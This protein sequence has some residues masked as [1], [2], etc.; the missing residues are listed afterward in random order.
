MTLAIILDLI[1][2]G[3]LVATISYA[4]ILNRRLITIQKS[5]TELQKFIDHFT[6]SLAKAEAS[7]QELKQTGQK[8]M[9]SVLEPLPQAKVL[10]D[11]LVF[12]LEKGESLAER[13][14]NFIRTARK[15]G[16]EETQPVSIL[17]VS[18][19][20]GPVRSDTSPDIILSLGNI[21]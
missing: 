14:E 2:I 19:D 15:T 16:K 12:L 4:V 5:R 17:S 20:A 8:V 21:R 6:I 3:F 9:D 13:L 1:V 7:V 10:R 18:N 11:D